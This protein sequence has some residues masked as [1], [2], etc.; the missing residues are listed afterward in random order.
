MKDDATI[1]RIAEHLAS[2]GARLAD[3][4][5]DLLADEIA[6]VVASARRLGVAPVATEVLAD[7]TEPDVAR[8]RAFARVAAALSAVE[9]GAARRAMTPAA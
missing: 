3:E 9:P 5:F 2:V 8:Y 6:L 4:G 7:P 1:D